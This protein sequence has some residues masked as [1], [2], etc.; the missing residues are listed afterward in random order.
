MAELKKLM[1]VASHTKACD[2]TCLILKHAHESSQALYA[3]YEIARTV[4]S[5]Q[6][7]SEK[8]GESKREKF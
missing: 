3:A 5:I 8:K 7:Q 1:F 2:K 6:K 4:R